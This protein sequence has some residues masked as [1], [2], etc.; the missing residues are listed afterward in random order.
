MRWSPTELI[1]D[2]WRWFPLKEGDLLFTGT[3][4]GVGPLEHGDHLKVRG[5]PVEYEL[6]VA[7]D[8]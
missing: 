1:E 5:G 3:P 7:R 4:A 6:T 8:L 2:L